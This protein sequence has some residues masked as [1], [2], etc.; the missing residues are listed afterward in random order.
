MLLRVVRG[1]HVFTPVPRP[2]IYPL[3]DLKYPKFGTTYPCLRVLG[4]SWLISQG[5]KRSQVS[6]CCF[7]SQCRHISCFL[8]PPASHSLSFFSLWPGQDGLAYI[9]PEFDAKKRQ[10]KGCVLYPVAKV[11][12]PVHFA[13]RSN[14]V[15][16]SICAIARRDCAT[17]R[18]GFL[19][20]AS[21]LTQ[22]Y[23]YIELYSEATAV[24]HS[25]PRTCDP[26]PAFRDNAPASSTAGPRRT[27]RSV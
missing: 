14:P 8:P 9:T 5:R 1:I 20:T 19:L 13:T 7:E 25:R 2:S 24:I 6:K 11:D 10:L 12:S 26:T 23:S 15:I 18:M 27:T 17:F 16:T 21:A 3:L 22:L 4:W